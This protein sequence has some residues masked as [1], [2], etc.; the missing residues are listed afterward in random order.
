M[1]RERRLQWLTYNARNTGL[2][3]LAALGKKFYEEKLK[4]ILEPQH[5]GEFVAVEPYS[6]KY[7]V[8]K[9]STQVALKALAEMPG[10]KF[11]FAR[12]GY[13]YAHKIGGSWLKKKV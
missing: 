13:Q 7:F 10:K 5:N 2:S 6:E 9:D 3:E 12:I 1:K 11:F 4:A 8:D